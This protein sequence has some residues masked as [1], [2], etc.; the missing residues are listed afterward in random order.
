MPSSHP[1]LMRGDILQP[2]DVFVGAD[3]SQLLAVAV[4]EHS[5]VRHSSLPCRVTPLID[6]DLP[7]PRDV[8]QG[9]R[10]NFSFA[11][12]AIPEVK[13]FAGRA[14]Y[15]DA[16]MLVLRDI[17]RLWSIPFGGAK[18]IIQEEVPDALAA[19]AKHG[20]PVRRKKQCSVMLIDCERTEWRAAEIIAGL[21]GR[22]SYEQLLENLCILDE[23]EIRYAVPFAWNSLEH[24]DRDTC[25][26]HYTDM[27]TQ[28]WVSPF[29]RNG[30]LWMDEVAL[31]LSSGAL[32]WDEL[33]A[34]VAAGY[35]RPSIIAEIEERP[36][37]A[38]WNADAAARYDQRD[39]AAGF[40]KHAEVYARK[41]ARAQAVKQFEAEFD[42][43][44]VA[45][46]AR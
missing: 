40:S 20:A 28:P 16:D 21:D 39:R 2:V 31:M 24:H 17:A 36:H 18:I 4:L 33:H 43:G 19:R 12:F 14:I 9:S 15:L 11:R 29:N 27:A 46:L 8:R 6:L 10:T 30:Q 45:A 37:A 38:G 3:R 5:I 7:E 32:S 34:E 22:Y 13:R 23:A 44:E 26:I 1:D 35:F 41:K 25:L 42:G